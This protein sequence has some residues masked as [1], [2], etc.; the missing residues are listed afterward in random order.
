MKAHM[1]VMFQ[2]SVLRTGS[3]LD[4]HFCALFQVSGYTWSASQMFSRN[5]NRTMRS[6][7]QAR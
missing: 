7:F 3:A 6:V 5:L 1:G 2:I 4:C